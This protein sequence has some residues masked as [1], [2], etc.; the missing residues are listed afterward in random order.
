MF[1]PLI[2]RPT[3]PR[4]N[5]QPIISYLAREEYNILGEECGRQLRDGGHE[6]EDLPR[7]HCAVPSLEMFRSPHVRSREGRNGEQYRNASSIEGPE[8]NGAGRKKL[9]R[10]MVQRTDGRG[11]WPNNMN[12][13]I[14]EESE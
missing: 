5:G 10:M 7:G 6:E 2:S 8:N 1:L 12:A 13:Q 11:D 9:R 4:H 3:Q 14:T